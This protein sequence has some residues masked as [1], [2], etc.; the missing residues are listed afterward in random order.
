MR[1]LPHLFDI[2]TAQPVH[3]L[4]S[5]HGRVVQ[6]LAAMMTG[7]MAVPAGLFGEAADHRP[8]SFMQYEQI[9]STA[10]VP[11]DGVMMKHAGMMDVMC[12]DFCSLEL[13][14]DRIM[15]AADDPGIDRIVLW[16]NTPGGQHVGT[17]ELAAL[18]KSIADSDTDIIAFSDSMMCSAGYYVASQ[19]D[20]VLATRSAMVGSINTRLFFLDDSKM[21]ADLGLKPELFTE[22]KYKGMFMPGMALTDEQRDLLSAQVRDIAAEFHADVQSGRGGDVPAEALEGQTF[23]GQAAVDA[24]LVDGIV[25]DISEALDWEQTPEN[26]VNP[27]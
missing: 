12:G 8:S 21:L 23:S 11:L 20:A 19:A 15:D 17:P 5:A 3:M 4:P 16:I 9:G 6:T 13:L 2:A 25:A 27:L 10:I 22:G 14:T 24:R 26:A 1:N 7:D 18:V